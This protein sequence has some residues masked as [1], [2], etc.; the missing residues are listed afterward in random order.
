MTNSTPTVTPV[1]AGG[2]P[3][4]TAQQVLDALNSA[5]DDILDAVDAGDSGLR[6]GINL[7]V[8]AAIAYLRGDADDLDSV[9]DKSYSE[10]LCTILDWIREA[11]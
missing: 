11:T 6:D 4:F 1:A 9:A 8:N 10:P 7:M 3:G 5:A 2:E